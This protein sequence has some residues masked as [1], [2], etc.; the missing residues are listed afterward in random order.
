MA[1][2]IDSSLAPVLLS[3]TFSVPPLLLSFATR[4][5]ATYSALF[6]VVSVRPSVCH[7]PVLYRDDWKN[8]DGFWHGG[9]LPPIPQ[10][11]VRKFGHL[12]N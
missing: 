8:R 1:D 4:R 12:Q 11:V 3:I 10:C 2:F 9:F 7:K 6:V 5:Y